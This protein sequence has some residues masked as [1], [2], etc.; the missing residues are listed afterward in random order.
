M[1]SGDNMSN[2]CCILIS[3]CDKYEDAWLPF[4][5]FFKKHWSNC[6][7]QIYL[8]TEKKYYQD[9]E[10]NIITLNCTDNNLSWSQRLRNALTRIKTDYIIF[11]LE[12]FFLLDYVN[13][14]ELNHCLDLMEANKK[15][16]V[17]D[18]EPIGGIN[19]GTVYSSDEKYCVRSLSSMYF[20]NCQSSIWRRKDLIEFLSPY[21]SPWQFEIFGS[22]RVKLY[23]K[24]FLLQ[25]TDSHK[26]FTY[27]VNWTTGYGLHAGK[28]LKSNIELFKKNGISVD[29]S[30]MGFFVGED[31]TAPKCPAPK[32]TLKF[33]IMYLLFSGGHIKQRMSIAEQLGYFLKHPKEFL[34]M[35][36]EKVIRCCT[37]DFFKDEE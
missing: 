16:A 29:F 6:P 7:Y 22:E 4:F 26:V 19:T 9:D 37:A 11:M 20:L 28:W 32:V 8:N 31:V 2:K 5:S 21:E 15:I 14:K 24:L 33:R 1:S 10:L 23:N 27:N 17:I 3:S 30:K 25:T 18:F 35:V 13:Q 36:K 34:Y 12:D